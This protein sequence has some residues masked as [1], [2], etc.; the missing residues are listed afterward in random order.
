MHNSRGARSDPVLLVGD[1]LT[2]IVVGGTAQRPVL[3]MQ[4]EDEPF[5]RMNS[6]SA[7][8]LVSSLFLESIKQPPSAVC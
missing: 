4:V 2:D 3:D 6:G 1:F 7:A 8:T 5:R